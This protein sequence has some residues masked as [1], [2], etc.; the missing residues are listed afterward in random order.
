MEKLNEFTAND[1]GL[2]GWGRNPVPKP[3]TSGVE[4]RDL[5]IVPAAMFGASRII[6]IV[7]HMPL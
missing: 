7:T 6:S 4:T 3:G 1:G 5:A 2:P